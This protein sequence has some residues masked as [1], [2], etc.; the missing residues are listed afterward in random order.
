MQTSRITSEVQETLAGLHAVD[1]K[2]EGFAPNMIVRLANDVM[3]KRF[4]SKNDQYR[5]DTLRDWH[6]SLHD[7]FTRALNVLEAILEDVEAEEIQDP[8]EELTD[9]LLE[10]ESEFVST[11]RKL[12]EAYHTV[13]LETENSEGASQTR[14]MLRDITDLYKKIVGVLQEIRWSIHIHDALREPVVGP[15]IKSGTDFIAALDEP[16]PT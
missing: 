10:A 11:H 2:P 16:D 14:K 9:A 7:Q 5:A 12:E 13:V 1:S 3:A 15:L 4:T 8:N 6:K